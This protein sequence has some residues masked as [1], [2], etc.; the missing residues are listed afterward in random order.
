MFIV[1]SPSY[2]PGEDTVTRKNYYL[3]IILCLLFLGLILLVESFTR[4][5]VWLQKL[6]FD[7]VTHDWL[8]TG[9]SHQQYRWIFYGGAKKAISIFAGVCGAGLLAG[10]LKQ[11]W[12][13]LIFPCL[14][15]LFSMAVVPATASSGKKYTNIYCPKEITE[16]GGP[17]EYQHVLECRRPENVN[18]KLGRCF[19]AAHASGGFALM[20]LYFCLPHKRWLGLSI[21]LAAGWIMG[22]YQMLR[23]DHFFSH[24]LTTMILA[25]LLILLVLPL[26]NRLTAWYL[27]K[28]NC[29]P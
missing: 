12:R 9:E 22:N 13:G 4:L 16:F 10:L 2:F 21:G 1:Y 11:Q 28:R 7:S 24:T 27:R 20:A 23:G 14:L 17:F 6:W 25:W 5:D 29:L 18:K 19:P 8:I 26:A 15:L 3:Q